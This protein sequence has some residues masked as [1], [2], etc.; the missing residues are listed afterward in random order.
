MMPSATYIIANI[1]GNKEIIAGNPKSFS[2]L[3]ESHSEKA[4][5]ATMKI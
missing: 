5:S 2:I 4:K 3:F 1:I